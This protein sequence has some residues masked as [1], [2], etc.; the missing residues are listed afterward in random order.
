MNRSPIVMV[1]DDNEA[2]RDILK[3]RLTAAGYATIEA[4]DGEEDY[5]RHTSIGRT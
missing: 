3:T 1:V 2:N 5:E 4:G